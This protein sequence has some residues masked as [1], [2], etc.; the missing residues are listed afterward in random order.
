MKVRLNYLPGEEWPEKE[1]IKGV[2][3][4]EDLSELGD[5]WGGISTN[6]IK[7]ALET[8]LTA[9]KHN[10]FYE[11]AKCV[12]LPREQVVLD[13]MRCYVKFNPEIKNEIEEAIEAILK[14]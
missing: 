11:M 1:V 8:S 9:G 2:L 5:I 6:D 13:L 3:K 10:E 4:V 14:V 12:S 7:I